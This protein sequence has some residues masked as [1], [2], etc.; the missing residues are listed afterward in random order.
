MTEEELEAM[1]RELEWYS[2]HPD[3]PYFDGSKVELLKIDKL[4]EPIPM[5][6]SNWKP[7]S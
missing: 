7:R 2:R 4:P 1:K 6:I 3:L 5:D